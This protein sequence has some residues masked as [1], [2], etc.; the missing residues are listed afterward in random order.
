MSHSHIG[1]YSLFWPANN[2]NGE[3]PGQLD[4]PHFQKDLSDVW[5]EIPFR[6]VSST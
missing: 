4:D 5:A 6:N 2:K 1:Y 3:V